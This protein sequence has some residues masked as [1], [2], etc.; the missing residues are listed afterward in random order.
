M[1]GQFFN[2]IMRTNYE[3]IKLVDLELKLNEEREPI[4]EQLG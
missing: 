2:Q 1:P 3:L 4:E